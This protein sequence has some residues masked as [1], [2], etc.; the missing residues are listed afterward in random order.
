ME[1]VRLRRPVQRGRT[2]RPRSRPF[3]SDAHRNLLFLI[4]LIQGNVLHA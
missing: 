2:D 4:E 1:A 3:L